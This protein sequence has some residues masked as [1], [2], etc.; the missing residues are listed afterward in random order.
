MASLLKAE[1]MSRFNALASSPGIAG[2]SLADI[3]SPSA[4]VSMFN[5]D[6]SNLKAF[7]SASSSMLNRFSIEKSEPDSSSSANSLPLNTSMVG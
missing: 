3:P 4:L 6:S 5:F 1:V 2:R 7:C